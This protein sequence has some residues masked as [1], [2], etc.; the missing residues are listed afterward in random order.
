MMRL[1]PERVPCSSLYRKARSTA[2][3]LRLKH[4]EIVK[5]IR[6]SSMFSV[7]LSS[8]LPR[9]AKFFYRSPDW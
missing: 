2:T 5:S 6:R 3:C 4:H 8:E 7:G 1:Q 9:Q